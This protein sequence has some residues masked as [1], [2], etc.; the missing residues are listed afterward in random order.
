MN[1]TLGLSVACLALAA[2]VFSLAPAAP[3]RSDLQ[4]DVE[5]LQAEVAELKRANN[6]VD[7]LALKRELNAATQKLADTQGYLAAQA[8]A[9]AALVTA[10]ADAE[11]KGFTFGI[12]PESRVALLQGFRAYCEELQKDVPGRKAPTTEPAPTK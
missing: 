9:A 5:R 11:K 7:V 6:A 1:R 2:A 3:V 4:K 12:N 10:L 8:D